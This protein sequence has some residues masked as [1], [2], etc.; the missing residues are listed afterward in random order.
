MKLTPLGPDGVVLLEGAAAG[1]ERG[2]VVRTVDR[3]ALAPAGISLQVDYCLESSNVRA[4][5]LRGMHWQ[6]APHGETKLVHCIRGALYDVVLDLRD[7]PGRGRWVAVELAAGDGRTL[8]VPP[9][10]AHGFQTLADDT[11]VQYLIGGRYVPAAA[12]GVRWDDPAFG[13]DWPAAPAGGR[14]IG[15]RDAAWPDHVP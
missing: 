6:A 3:A 7:G 9:G 1:D 8:H 14:T 4:G 12:R 13:I 10:C 15:A 5:T 11:V 2:A